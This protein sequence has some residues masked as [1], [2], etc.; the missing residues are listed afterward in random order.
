MIN[1]IPVP[2]HLPKGMTVIQPI[3]ADGYVIVHIDLS[4]ARCSQAQMHEIIDL[5][6]EINDRISH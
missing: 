5:V 3:Q 4:Y 2:D 6:N 1:R